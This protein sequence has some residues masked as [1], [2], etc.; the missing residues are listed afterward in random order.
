MAQ[1][2]NKLMLQIALHDLSITELLVMGCAM[3]Q[4]DG[5]ILDQILH[6][7]SSIDLDM[8]MEWIPPMCDGEILKAVEELI[9][10]KSAYTLDCDPYLNKA[11][12][13]GRV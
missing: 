13:Q 3:I 2:T 1:G 9:A 4:R 11:I 10:E 5:E 7:L 6:R 12:L 8:I